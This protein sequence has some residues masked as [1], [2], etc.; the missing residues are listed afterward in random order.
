MAQHL[1][2]FNKILFTKGGFLGTKCTEIVFIFGQG[3]A[4]TR[5]DATS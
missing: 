1:A 4:R 2:T 5:Y 3:F